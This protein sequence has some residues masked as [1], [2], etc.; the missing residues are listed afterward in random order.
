MKAARAD[1]APVERSE[2]LSQ[3]RRIVDGRECNDAPLARFGLRVT[4]DQLEEMLV[5]ESCKRLLVHEE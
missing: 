1:P 4:F 5:F 2:G 3:H